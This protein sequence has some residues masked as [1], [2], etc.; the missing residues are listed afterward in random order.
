M[1]PLD[2]S[3]VVRNLGKKYK[4]VPYLDE[5]IAKYSDD[6]WVYKYQPKQQDHHWHPSTSCLTPVSALHAVALESQVV[7]EVVD[8]S[9][10]TEP[11]G[12]PML[13]K[14]QVGHFWH[15]W[16]QYLVEQRLHF[17]TADDIE[18]KRVKAWGEGPFHAVA[19]SADIA[20]CVIPD[21]WTGGVD[22]KTMTSPVFLENAVPHGFAAKYE[23]QINIYMDLFE[24]PEWLMVCIDK[25]RQHNFKE[26]LY[27]RN[28]ALIKAIYTKWEYVSLLIDNGELPEEGDDEAF[29]VKSLLTGPIG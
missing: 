14:F 10:E 3:K 16:L 17:A 23:C 13:K 28:D 4:L 11:F 20:P 27:E 12:V 19:G 21:I 5:A 29:E 26:F 1:M 18:R 8:D 15:Q 2:R 24:Q 7:T 9:P 6:E 22:F 25:D